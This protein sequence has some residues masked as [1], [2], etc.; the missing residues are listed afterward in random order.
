MVAAAVEFADKTAP[1]YTPSP[2][3][4]E[5][6]RA[7]IL[8]ELGNARREREETERQA[9]NEEAQR[10]ARKAARAQ[11]EQAKALSVAPPAQEQVQV[12]AE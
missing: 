5:G 7:Y 1:H 3:V 4:P 2:P 6:V 12:A 9:R 10:I 8:T 11:R